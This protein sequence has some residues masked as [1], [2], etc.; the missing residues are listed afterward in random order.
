MLNLTDEELMELA[1]EDARG[2]MRGVDWWV[3]KLL[4]KGKVTIVYTHRKPDR[5][6]VES[7]MMI[8][9]SDNGARVD[10]Y[11]FQNLPPEMIETMETNSPTLN[12]MQIAAPFHDILR[13]SK[14]TKADVIMV[15]PA[16]YVVGRTPEI[17]RPI[18]QNLTEITEGLGI[19]VVLFMDFHPGNGYVHAVN[20]MDEKNCY[21][22]SPFA[23][24]S[25]V[26]IGDAEEMT[27][28]NKT[29]P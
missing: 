22:I 13:I 5:G 1:Q 10:Y 12:V 26:Y 27:K 25:V 17:A 8:V 28:S 23:P 6:F 11:D 16:E 19:S 2:P 7:Y 20:P 24:T 14:G 29:R 18:V 3:G 15:S 4:P 9:A 21:V